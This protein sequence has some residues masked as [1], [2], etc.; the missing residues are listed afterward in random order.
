MISSIVE[1]VEARKM[2]QAARKTMD[3]LLSDET[4]EMSQLMKMGPGLPLIEEVNGSEAPMKTREALRKVSGMWYIVRRTCNSKKS[5][6][7]LEFKEREIKIEDLF[8]EI[9]EKCILSNGL[10]M[11]C[12]GKGNKEAWHKDGE[13]KESKALE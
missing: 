10:A 12:M 9:R 7:H 4:Q 11:Q 8:L 13:V 2:D 6:S 3:V 5:S 1:Y